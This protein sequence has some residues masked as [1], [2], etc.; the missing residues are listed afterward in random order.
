[1]VTPASE[2]VALQALINGRL[3]ACDRAGA[4]RLALEA[5]AAGRITVPCLYEEVLAPV[6]TGVGKAWQAGSTAVWE[7][8]C[9]SATVRTIVE[10]LYATVQELAPPERTR[11]VA[12]LACPSQEQH[13]LGLRMFSDRLEL[14]G[15]RVVYLGADTPA[16]EIVAAAGA[17]GAGIVVLSGSTHYHRTMLRSFVEDLSARMPGVRVLIGGPAFAGACDEWCEGHVVDADELLGGDGGC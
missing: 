11:G 14:A 7:E 13:D 10:A 12:V 4:V 5:V 6:M 15:W 3:D 1:M 2:P 17:A 8:H 9:A 16:D